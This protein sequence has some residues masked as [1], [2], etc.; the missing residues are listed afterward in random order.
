MTFLLRSMSLIVSYFFPFCW[1]PF[2][3]RPTPPL[4]RSAISAIS[5]EFLRFMKTMTNFNLDFSS[6]SYH[7]RSYVLMLD[8]GIVL[9]MTEL[10]DLDGIFSDFLCPLTMP[11][12]R[13]R[14]FPFSINNDTEGLRERLIEIPKNHSIFC[15]FN[16]TE[17]RDW[18][19]FFI[20]A[21][22]MWAFH[23]SQRLTHTNL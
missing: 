1:L 6:F 23:L 3:V 22:W 19:Y 4:F 15:S 2:C 14:W 8:E 13:Q 7:L 20:F 10:D 17:S 18:R 5:M 16:I 9:N 11:V 12:W 21:I